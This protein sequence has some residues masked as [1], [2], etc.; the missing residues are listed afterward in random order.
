MLRSGEMQAWLPDAG[1]VKAW[2]PA[3]ALTSCPLG[4]CDNVTASEAGQKTFLSLRNFRAAPAFNG[5]GVQ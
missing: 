4:E 2:H 3:F 1:V 5:L